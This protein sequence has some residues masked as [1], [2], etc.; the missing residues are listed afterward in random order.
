MK[1]T[2]RGGDSRS[3][4]FTDY[5]STLQRSAQAD[6]DIFVNE[7]M[8]VTDFHRAELLD[9][10]GEIKQLSWNNAFLWGMKFALLGGFEKASDLL[11]ENPDEASFTIE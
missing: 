9:F 5:E 7:L 11:I 10:V 6:L 4:T 2:Y 8:G 3:F 1:I